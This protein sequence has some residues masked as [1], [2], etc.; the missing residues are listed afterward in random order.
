MC[1]Y[2]HVYLLM[3]V[4]ARTLFHFFSILFCLVYY[5]RLLTFFAYGFVA[6][7]AGVARCFIY[8][9]AVICRIYTNRVTLV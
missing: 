1:I 6:S 4:I 5:E 7:L 3:S 9:R 2:T 8:P